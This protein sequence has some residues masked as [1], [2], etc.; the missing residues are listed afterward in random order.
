MKRTSEP[1]IELNEAEWWSRW[2]R[3]RWIDDSSYL[4]LSEEFTEPFFN[5][6]GFLSCGAATADLSRVEEAFRHEGRTPCVSLFGSCAAV[7]KRMNG[8]G[9]SLFDK[10][11]VQRVGPDP[12]SLSAD[13]DV[14]T[15]RSGEAK[16]WTEAYL[17]SFYGDLALNSPTLR[18][19]NRLLGLRKV[20]LLVAELGGRV[21]GVTALYRSPGLMGLY[22]L[23]TVPECRGKGVARTLLGHSQRLAEK[24]GRAL[25]LQSLSS[26]ETEP[27]YSKF[28]FRRLYTKDLLMASGRV[29][30]TDRGGRR[31]KLRGAFNRDPGVGPHLFPE[32]FQGFEHLSAVRGT[33]GE[34]TEKV[35]SGLTVEVVDEEGYMHINAKEGAVVV[36]ASYLKEGDETYIYLDIIHELVHIRQHMEGKELWDRR[37]RY[38]DRPTEIEAYEVAVAEA[39]RMGLDDERIAD[40]LKVEWVS[41][42][43]FS[44]FLMTLGINR[45]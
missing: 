21:A 20:T 33:F 22:C 5:R 41:D 24:E 29:S 4:L 25:V 23:G 9:Y 27:F 3:L 45:A 6:G 42:E 39:R 43:D 36:S 17:L 14:R 12:I 38:V 30:A 8:D 32:V 7:L 11:I 2:G 31:Q 37:Y 28:G 10:M 26:E 19:T 15:I 35:L 16:V 44:R 34:E 40:Y 18:V 1:D 13:V